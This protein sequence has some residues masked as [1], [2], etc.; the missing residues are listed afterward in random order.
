MDKHQTCTRCIMTSKA[1][2]T[3]TFDAE[4]HCNYCNTAIAAGK[5]TYFP[6][7]KGKQK[8]QEMIDTLKRE[9]Q[10]KPCDG[11][12]GISGGLD[13]AYLAYLGT[14]K[15]GL[16]VTAIHIDDGFDTEIATENIRRLCENCK[17]NLITIKPEKKQYIE[18]I[19]AYMLAGVPNLAVPQDNALF[20]YLFH[21]ARDHKI[22][23]FLSGGNYALECILQQ[24]HTI[25][26]YDMENIKDINKKFG[27]D[28]L[29]RLDLMD[30]WEKHLNSPVNDLR[31]LNY[32]DYNRERAIKELNEFCDFQYYGAKHLENDFTA[33]LQLYWLPK[34]FGVD[35]RT[36]HLSSMI[37]SG[38]MTREEALKK[39]EEPLYN[40]AWMDRVVEDM[41]KAFDFSNAEWDELMAAPTHEHEDFKTDKR[42]KR[43]RLWHGV[44]HALYIRAC[45]AFRYI[46]GKSNK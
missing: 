33:F 4:G 21:Y 11:L 37:I 12:M 41:K 24:G 16:R 43:Y 20:T 2:P 28:D 3:I 14:Q 9:G 40:P 8:L 10:G 34:K 6:N 19:R 23:N 18:L 7:D 27:R 25:D 5:T 30:V 26:V 38:Q 45:G 32:I 31:P 35:K 22:E 39:M 15:W 44:R 29:D 17:I 13:S 42:F 1:D 36:S 46:A